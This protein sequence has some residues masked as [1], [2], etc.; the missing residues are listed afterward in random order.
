MDNSRCPE[1]RGD[2]VIEWD[3]GY[4]CRDCGLE[5]DRIEEGIAAD[6]EAV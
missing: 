2:D 1:C 4:Q 6:G 5:F 3:D